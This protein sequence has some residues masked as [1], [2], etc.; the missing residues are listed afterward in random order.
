MS[1]TPGDKLGPYEIL[2]PIGA[3][4]MGEVY[5][6]RDP[7]LN[8]DVAIKVSQERFSDRFEREARAVAALN[9]PN[10]CTLHDVGPDY[11]VMEF[12]EGESPK[13]P[14]PLEEA[15][16]IARQIADA[17]EAAHEKGIV[18]RDLKPANIKIKPDGTVKVLDFGLAKTAETASGDPASSPTMTISPTRAGMILGTA[19]YMSPEQARGK[20]VD[21]RADIWAF[22]VVLYEL[23]TGRMLFQG[24]DLTETVASV[25]KEKADLSGVP[26][27]VRPLLE[28]CLEKDPRKRLRDIGDMG[29]LLDA[30][31]APQAT[32]GTGQRLLWPAWAVAAALALGLAVSLWA[33]WRKTPPPAVLQRFQVAVPEQQGLAGPG[34][35]SAVVSVSPD[36]ARLLVAG[37][38]ADGVNRLFARRLDSIEM[39]P[40]AGSE[41]VAGNP[42]WS[43]DS[44]FLAFSTL[45]G[46]LKK[47]EAA[48]GP[49]QILCDSGFVWGGFWTP[50]GK[51]AFDGQNAQGE[52][53]LWEVPAAGGAVSRLPGAEHAA[54]E[55]RWLPELL[56]DGR[57]FLYS[58]RNRAGLL[59]LTYMGSLDARQG[60]LNPK[61]LL[62]QSAARVVYAPSPD[63]PGLGYLLFVR[64]AAPQG[65]RAG[66]LMAQPFDLRKLEPV[67]EPV[68]IA[69]RVLVTGFS[70]SRTGVLVYRTGEYGRRGATQLTLLD[71]Q[72]KIQGTAGEPDYN[73]QMAFSPDGARVVV[74]RLRENNQA[75]LDLWI[76]DLARDVSTRFT[77]DPGRYPVWSPDGN[78]VAYT[79]NLG[80]HLD[81]YQKLSN[82][83]GG[84]ELLLQSDE[85]KLPQ[86]WSRDGRFLLYGV[87]KT[88]GRPGTPIPL[89]VL[90]LDAKA[91][92]AGK[93]FL[94]APQAL[95]A[96][97]SPDMR[98][99][100]YASAESGRA[101]VYVRPFDP[102]SATG[103]PPGGG[104]FPVSKGGGDR[105][106]WGAD[107]KQLLYLAR[108]NTVMAVDVTANPVSRLGIPK[109]LFKPN[110]LASNPGA[111]TW[112]LSPDGKQFLF[113]ISVTSS[114]APE[115]ITVVLNWT[116]MLKK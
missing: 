38:G 43:P 18:H 115:P 52:G 100:A 20:T 77:S 12:I 109:P 51:I 81:L 42:L 34:A 47:I 11:L 59:G 97:F 98:W 53:N 50:D 88:L 14:L 80:G 48:G 112:D 99:V 56:P 19:A 83:G 114:A 111:A 35:L 107:G 110:G 66:I 49:A 78:R 116:A 90:P 60:Q 76:I 46:K 10:I 68:P 101:E 65:D 94:F 72:G 1:L 67:G 58:L 95:D 36:G 75:D 84:E 7:R 39:R 74:S 103:S 32:A 54:G 79:S 22:G 26:E 30:A 2:A 86:S 96:R 102:S 69:E 24:E 93:P 37:T 29:L 89:W 27:R 104:V 82:G 105:P 33:P 41:G 64:T 28:K 108:D 25:V 9:H 55:R 91:H 85:D 87:Q 3:G 62:T 106:R 63:D 8:R 23:L 70:A 31:P 5:R 113:P 17:L 21:K 16:R 71:R 13:G 45:E 73:R 15:L 61:Q 92:P 40:L 6:A 57:H 4:G 44:R